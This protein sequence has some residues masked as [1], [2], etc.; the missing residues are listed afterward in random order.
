MNAL[1]L[2]SSIF[3]TQNLCLPLWKGTI[4]FSTKH[5]CPQYAVLHLG[6][7]GFLVKCI[8]NLYSWLMRISYEVY[9]KSIFVFHDITYICIWCL[10]L[11]SNSMFVLYLKKVSLPI[12]WHHILVQ[13]IYFQKDRLVYECFDELRVKTLFQLTNQF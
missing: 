5:L 8:V 1:V 2:W 7:L 3:I 6:Q 13:M 4:V 11:A 10:M 12:I 9:S